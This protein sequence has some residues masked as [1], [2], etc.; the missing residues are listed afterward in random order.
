MPVVVCNKSASKNSWFLLLFLAFCFFN[1]FPQANYSIDKD[2]I[3]KRSEQSLLSTFNS[4]Y[5]D[6]SVLFLHEFTPRNF[7]GNISLSNPDYFVRFKSKAL[8]FS[9]FEA[10]LSD[11]KI[12]KEEIEYYKTKGPFAEM[13]GIAGS[14]QF[15]MF[16]MLFANTFKNSLNLS[17]KLNR[18]T[19]QGFY[20]KQQSFTNN[21][22]TALNYQ[23]K[24]KF[25]SFDV[26][27]LANNN[28]FQE[29]GGIIY[30]TLRNQ[31]LLVSKDL[32]PTKISDGSRDNRELTAM[33]N[34]L[35]RLSK[36]SEDENKLKTY[37]Q[38]KSSYNLNKYKY[39]D[40][41]SGTDNN[42]LIYYL[43]TVSTKDSTRVLILQNQAGLVLKNKSIT[44][45]L[46]YL[47][48]YNNVW[49]YYDSTF[50]S[51]IAKAELMHVKQF[52][53]S[54]TL[55]THLLLNTLKAEYIAAGN[56]SGD[57]KLE[58]LHSLSGFN[59]LKKTY[60]LNLRLLTENRT[61][62]YLLRNWYSNHFI[63]TNTF[64]TIQTTQCEL[65][66]NYSF[67]KIGGTFQS[68][69]N[70]IYFDQL[71]YPMQYSGN[72]NKVAANVSIDKVLFKHL[73][74]RFNHTLQNS[75]SNVILLPQNISHAAIYYCGN[76]FKNAL[77]LNTGASVE[78]YSEFTP[79]AY[80]PATQMFYL[81]ENTAAGEFAFV[82]VFLNAR[83]RP[84][85]FFFKVENVLH[86][87]L[88][89][90]YSMVKSY[91]QPDRAIRFGLTWTF[92]D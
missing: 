85:S 25:Y 76:L 28:R 17:L 58:S 62:D 6:T 75:S 52:K 9:L 21:F 34:N 4:A 7:L 26:Y 55:K 78:Y 32:I 15:Q 60:H 41:N 57:Y 14:K 46:N 82:D 35:F 77:Q 73:G 74:L 30:D 89:T 87:L 65:T 24:N 91:Y 1:I 53:N 10:P 49:Q 88:G 84:V 29:N 44:A 61:P 66:F 42:Y 16:K 69:N 68:I 70:Y 33:L 81:Q 20:T 18:Y 63:W 90:N 79:Y 12:L 83:I 5:P 39:T 86:G 67:L 37:L 8:G 38:I 36:N 43:D 23:T 40:K 54:D 80:M 19:S 92:F 48:E 64:N 56:Q 11:Y 50:I 59:N 71:G 22:Y 72:I 31:D 47:N 45:Q 2:Y 27:L 3:K 13:T 51:H